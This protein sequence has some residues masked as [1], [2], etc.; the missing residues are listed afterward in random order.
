[1]NAVTATIRELRT[2]FRGVK[3]K[4]EENGHVIITDNGV[5]SYKLETLPTPP[6][7]TQRVSMP[8]Y[9]ARLLKRQPKPM[10][11]EETRRFWDEER[12]AR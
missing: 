12:D 11:K 6:R 7:T 1:M 10:S 8:D 2:D 3:R 5:P 4:L 9:Y